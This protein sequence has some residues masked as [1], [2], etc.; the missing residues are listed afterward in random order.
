MKI[1]I[2][3][4]FLTHPQ[5][6]GFKTYTE[7]LIAALACVDEENEYILYLDRSPDQKTDLPQ[8][9]NFS[10]KVLSQFPLVGMP[11][12]EQVQ[13]RVQI[14]KDRIDLLHSPCLTAPLW[15]DCPLVVTVHDMIW[16][17][18]EKFSNPR[19]WSIRRKLMGWYNSAVSKQAIERASAIITVSQA[20]K[21]SILEHIKLENTRIFVTHEAVKPAFRQVKDSQPINVI[22]HK[23]HLPSDFI[24][25]IGSPD[26]RKNI[27]RLVQAYSLLPKDLR[28]KYLLVIVWTHSLLAHEIADQAERSQLGNNIRFLQSVSDDDLILLY[29]AASLFAFP[30]LYEGFGLPP[31]E[32]MACGAPVV[33]ANNSSIPEIVG[34]AAVLL[35]AQDVNAIC[36]SMNRILTDNSLRTAM[37]NKGIERAASFSWEKC[38]RETLAVYKSVL[39]S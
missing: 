11:W 34:D 27:S 3:A 18:P 17:F 8:R 30:S 20:A 25:A 22:R 32:A 7:N 24:L 15:P 38:A 35:D 28:E 26:P 4:R 36:N 13:L 6:G 9:P 5:K 33:A 39:S 29:N 31:L 10:H 23:Y 16:A 37:I 14:A 21:E 19:L 12:R 1:G 2:D